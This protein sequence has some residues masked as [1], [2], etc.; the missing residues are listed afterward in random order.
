MPLYEFR[1]QECGAR[2]EVFARSM[3]TEV[4]APPCPA[5]PGEP[6]HQMVRAIS[7]FQRHLTEQDKIAEA[8]A[9]WGSE[10]DAAMGPAPDV[11]RYARRYDELAKDLPPD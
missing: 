7:Q 11:D 5:H 9:R 3:N 4:Q 1:C 6:N 2:D 10:I 8:E